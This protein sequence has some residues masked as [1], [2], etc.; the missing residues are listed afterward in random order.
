MNGTFG[1][2]LKER[3]LPAIRAQGALLHYSSGV[4]VNASSAVRPASL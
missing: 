3:A 1:A 4:Q 2:N